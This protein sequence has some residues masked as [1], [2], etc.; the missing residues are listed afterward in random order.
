M[1]RKHKCASCR[2]LV[3]PTS[4]E[5]S[6]S[7]W[8]TRLRTKGKDC[9]S[10]NMTLDETIKLAVT[11]HTPSD[12]L[13]REIIAKDMDS[14]MVIDSARTLEVTRGEVRFMKAL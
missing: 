5:E 14:K 2:F 1:D 3:K 7:H 12:K 9:E 4:P 6:R 13:E 11:L 8:I 10:E